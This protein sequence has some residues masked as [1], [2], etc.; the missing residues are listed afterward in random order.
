MAGIKDEG[1]KIDIAYTTQ[2]GWIRILQALV[3]VGCY[4][5]SEGTNMPSN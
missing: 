5:V 1:Y 2:N 3:K 4:C